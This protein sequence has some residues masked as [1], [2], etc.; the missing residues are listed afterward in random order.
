MP[1]P[2]QAAI[3][4]A[5]G[6]I[7]ALPP[8]DETL[9]RMMEHN[10]DRGKYDKALPIR[11][12]LSSISDFLAPFC[13]EDQSERF[14]EIPSAVVGPIIAALDQVTTIANLM[15][16]MCRPDVTSGP[17]PPSYQGG[18]QGIARHVETLHGRLFLALNIS[19]LR[20]RPQ[21][22]RKRRR[23]TPILLK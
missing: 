3:Q 6:A 17:V 8:T 13:E 16:Q 5:C 23:A 7:R 1:H 2:L 18:E 20:R 4:D 9:Q 14:E 12:Q 10:I 19:S 21:L 11:Q 22:P 15:P